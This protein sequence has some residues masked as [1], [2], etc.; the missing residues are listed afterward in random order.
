MKRLMKRL[1]LSDDERRIPL[2]M[3]AKTGW[4]DFKAYLIEGF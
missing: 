3:A 2:L 4:G 1:I